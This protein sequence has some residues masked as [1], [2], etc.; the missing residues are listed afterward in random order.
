MLAIFLPIEIAASLANQGLTRV[1]WAHN[2]LLSAYRSRSSWPALRARRESGAWIKPLEIVAAMFATGPS[3]G[4]CW[5]YDVIVRGKLSSGEPVYFGLPDSSRTSAPSRS[6]HITGGASPVKDPAGNRR[7]QVRPE[8]RLSFV[9][10]Q[11]GLR[12]E[13]AWMDVYARSRRKGDA[14]GKYTDGFGN[15][16]STALIE[17]GPSVP[18]HQAHERS[19]ESLAL[20][21]G[22]YIYVT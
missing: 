1:Q 15:M 6:R 11:V 13:R 17:S 18:R 2:L 4:G 7:Q 5:T 21:R 12:H 8:G 14:P 20:S 16:D 9:T 19:E 3:E 22:E 10:N